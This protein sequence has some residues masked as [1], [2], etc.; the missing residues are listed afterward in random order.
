MQ[1]H[2]A[3]TAGPTQVA[4]ISAII[5]I[6]LL[7]LG[8]FVF[9]CFPFFWRA[10]FYQVFKK[11][12]AVLVNYHTASYHTLESESIVLKYSDE[13]RRISAFVLDTAERY[14]DAVAE[15]MNYRPQNK[16]LLIIYPDQKTLN[17]SFGWAGDKSTAGAY[18][19]GSVRILSPL[20][21]A[22]EEKDDVR[23]KSVFLTQG[24]VSHELAHYVIDEKTGGNYPRWLSEGLAQYVEE[25]ITG[26]R[27]EVPSLEQQK[28]LYPLS[29][30]DRGFDNL[31]DQTLAYWQSLHT[32]NF[33]LDRYGMEKM[34]DLLTALQT[35][36]KLEQAFRQVYDLPVAELEQ[37]LQGQLK[38]YH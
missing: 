8:L 9:S 31:P 29:Q 34:Q 21:L 7:L 28:E 6:A 35:G 11:G 12:A 23:I 37:Q 15:I 25:K 38:I 19:A 10:T 36:L 14:Y 26:F 13:D 1:T 3:V 5:L 27:L 22:G 20:A 30:M 24:P 32:V 2:T 17:K 33:L 4:R 16:V 18:W